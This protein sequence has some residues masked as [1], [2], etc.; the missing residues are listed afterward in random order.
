MNFTKEIFQKR[1]IRIEFAEK[2]ESFGISLAQYT[3]AFK[4]NNLSV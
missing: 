1:K 4:M 2:L 3:S